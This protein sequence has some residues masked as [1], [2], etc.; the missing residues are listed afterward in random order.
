MARR[1]G[2]IAERIAAMAASTSSIALQMVSGDAV[3]GSWASIACRPSATLDSLL[4]AVSVSS[5]AT[6]SRSSST[7]SCCS[8]SCAFASHSAIAA[9]TANVFILTT[10]ETENISRSRRCTTARLPSTSLSACSGT[11]NAGP[12]SSGHAGGRYNRG[13]VWASVSNTGSRSRITRSGHRL[14]EGNHAAFEAFGAGPLDDL[15][16]EGRLV[17]TRE[18]DHR[19]IHAGESRA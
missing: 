3:G 16:D 14:G 11:N 18:R 10:S 4:M 8:R 5:A 1:T 12:R 15:D 17:G 6:R 19:E 2:R 13:S 7:R 9:C